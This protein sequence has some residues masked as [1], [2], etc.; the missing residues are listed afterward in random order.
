MAEGSTVV[1]GE[2]IL[3]VRPTRRPSG[4]T[5]HNTMWLAKPHGHPVGWRRDPARPGTWLGVCADEAEIVPAWQ[6]G[7]RR[8]LVDLVR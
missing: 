5:C 4:N 8:V 3:D 1:S 6:K 2:D 7:D